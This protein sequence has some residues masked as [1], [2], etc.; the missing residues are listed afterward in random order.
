MILFQKVN[1]IYNYGYFVTALVSFL[2]EFM[3]RQGLHFKFSKKVV[4]SWQL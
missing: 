1:E 2:Y 4:S 3:G